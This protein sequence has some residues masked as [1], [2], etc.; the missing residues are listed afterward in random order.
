M[1]KT[2]G[3]MRLIDGNHRIEAVRKF[4][5]YRREENRPKIECILK[6]YQDLTEEEERQVYSDEAKRRNESFED[7]L[8]LYKDSLPFWKLCLYF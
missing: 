8:N 6:V 7:R 4:Y 1:N 5:S 2:K 3:K